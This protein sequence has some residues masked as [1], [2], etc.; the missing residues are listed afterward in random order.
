[1][2][3]EI[4]GVTYDEPE[5]ATPKSET[6][7]SDESKQEPQVNSF[8]PVEYNAIGNL[9]PDLQRALLV[10]KQ[11]MENSQFLQK[12]ERVIASA[13]GAKTWG[14]DLEETTRR[15]LVRWADKYGVD[16]ATEIDI[17]GT[18]EKP[19][20]YLKAA[21][22]IN[23][24]AD[25]IASGKVEYAYA[26]H[27]NADPRFDSYAEGEVDREFGELLSKESKRRKFQRA[28]HG[29]PEEAAGAVIFRVKLRD[30]PRE[31]VG[32]NWTGGD[33]KVKMGRGGE[34]MKGDRGDPIG[35]MEPIKTAETRAAR[36]CLRLCISHVPVLAD[37]IA[38]MQGDSEDL[39]E[40][41]AADRAVFDA[42]AGNGPTP[43]RT[44]VDPY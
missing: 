19:G 3:K 20:I 41:I 4:P 22:Y 12:Q 34:Q 16:P 14:G 38:A 15:A 1:M 31:L 11:I 27:V 9:P 24:L 29:I 30:M 10:R 42:Q 26:D 21:Y 23:R 43:I 40:Q 6:P 35:A 13:L 7:K 37:R 8:L 33:T 36:R 17:L 28:L 18:R 2:S 5:T 32:Q 25:L 44:H 39:S